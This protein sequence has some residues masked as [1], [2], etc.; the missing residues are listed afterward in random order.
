[1]P[2]QKL[3]IKILQCKFVAIVYIWLTAHLAN[4]L[5]LKFASISHKLYLVRL[6]RASPP[7]EPGTSCL[8]CPLTPLSRNR[9]KNEQ[10]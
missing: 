2:K 9:A 5:I 8:F 3:A 7:A 6:F 4:I 10:L 1:M